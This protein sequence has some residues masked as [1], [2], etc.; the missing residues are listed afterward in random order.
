[1]D[2]KYVSR[3]KSVELMSTVGAGLLGAG[4]ALLF[5]ER[6]GAFAVPILVSGLVAHALGMY[7]KHK[8]EEAL[9]PL[10]GWINALYWACWA[11]LAG[12]TVFIVAS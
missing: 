12:L 5:R 3:I 2:T 4:L 9:S 1:M 10:P 11:L 8:W 6:L 7:L